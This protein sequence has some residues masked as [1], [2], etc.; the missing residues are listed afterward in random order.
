MARVVNQL[1]LRWVLGWRHMA[2][3][4][5]AQLS[6]TH[7]VRKHSV[8]S[9]GVDSNH[10]LRAAVYQLIKADDI[11]AVL[12]SGDLVERGEI[13]EYFELRNILDPLMGLKP[14]YLMLGNHDVRDNFLGL[15]RDYPFINQ[16]NN[17]W[18]VQY[19]V[20]LNDTH[21]LVVLDTLKEGRDAGYLSA[22]KLIWL[23]R[24]LERH[25][26][27]S[28]LLAMHHPMID[29]GNSMMNKMNLVNQSDLSAV[30]QKH[31]NVNRIFC[32]HIHREITDAFGTIPVQV[33]PSTAFA[34][35]A[36]LN[37]SNVDQ[38]CRDNPG[39][40]V[41]EITDGVLTS[42]RHYLDLHAS[43]ATA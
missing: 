42:K 21:A 36:N 5:L 15:F 8:L 24:T 32:G 2:S 7:V 39:Y 1:L 3:F 22:D 4:K 35:P 17:S 9:N 41:H 16:A 6:D 18:G 28:V 40:L 37:E 30:L 27:K 11:D 34:Y 10:A 43:L 13:Y 19:S 20:T 29:V 12:L 38:L 33:C 31:K 23:D 26:E 14:V 25:R